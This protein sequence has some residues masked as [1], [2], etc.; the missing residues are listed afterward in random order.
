M[1]FPHFFG[2]R[3]TSTKFSIDKGK[4][5]EVNLPGAKDHEYPKE[6]TKDKDTR[7][8]DDIKEQEDID[9]RVEGDNKRDK[10]A[11]RPELASDKKGDKTVKNNEALTSNKT[12]TQAS[13]EGIYSLFWN[14]KLTYNLR[15]K[16]YSKTATFLPNA[17]ALQELLYQAAP[18]VGRSKYIQKHE[19][20]YNEYAVSVGYFIL[21]YV[22]IL[23]AKQAASNLDG[24]ESNLLTR[25]FKMHPEESIPIAEHL[26][27]F[28]NTIVSTEL[29]DRRYSWICPDYQM[30]GENIGARTLLEFT[31]S[32]GRHFIQPQIPHM[33]AI[34]A[35]F[36]AMDET[37]MIAAIDTAGTFRVRPLGANDTFF[38]RTGAGRLDFTD[39]NGAADENHLILA[40]CGL[41]YPFRFFNQNAN[42]ARLRIRE[43]DFY[44]TKGVNF[45]FEQI[46]TEYTETAFDNTKLMTT[47]DNFLNMEKSKN[48]KWFGYL[49]EQMAIYSKCFNTQY[50]LSQVG[51][52]GGLE[53]SVVMHLRTETAHTGGRFLYDN[54]NLG[55][56]H[57]NQIS[58]YPRRFQNM[59]A[60]ASTSR[61]GV[62]RNEELQALTFATNS[63][64]PINGLT[65]NQFRRGKYFDHSGQDPGN[66]DC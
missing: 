30:G 12:V 23:R 38:G 48:L 8:K 35:S 11:D 44:G 59:T 10:K 21:F 32:H 45:K 47:I 52:T 62:D 39:G 46:G 53:S 54:L 36:G 50:N 63:T 5:K 43:T 61:A 25:L 33:L 1:P 18:I 4:S 29:E 31:A 41:S 9:N 40:T 3:G 7:K 27:P 14:N 58:W 60:H 49:K 66:S 56:E 64:P 17:M 34:L 6:E 57:P 22:Q 16:Q 2:K 15:A 55:I 26:F 42:D 37:E 13:P 19:P 24:I 51:T 65:L 20:T 28:F